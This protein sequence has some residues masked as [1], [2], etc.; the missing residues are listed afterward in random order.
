MN[1][2]A[3][4]VTYTV[5]GLVALGVGTFECLEKRFCKKE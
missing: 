4:L 1:P 3:L 2:L 5:Y